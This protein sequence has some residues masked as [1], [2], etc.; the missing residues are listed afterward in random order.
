MK[1]RLSANFPHG[2]TN[3]DIIV[4]IGLVAISIIV[5][6]VV[7]SPGDALGHQHDRTRHDDVRNYTE[8]LYQL[9]HG[10]PAVF[11]AL[12]NNLSSFRAMIGT[13]ESCEGSFGLH[14]GDSVL[15]DDCVDLAP[16]ISPDYLSPLP[17]D[18]SGGYSQEHTG[19]YIS[20]DQ[21]VMEIGACDP[22]G[23]GTITIE[24]QL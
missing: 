15:A 19:Y 7:A 17:V 23:P 22:Y 14:C 13:G 10:E 24:T 18:P 9:Y 6:A 1:S 11:D 2:Y 16:Y 5:I 12:D 3:A 8:A 4:A 21:G 20:L